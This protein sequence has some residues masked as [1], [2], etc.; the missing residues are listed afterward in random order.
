MQYKNLKK[1][2]L[3]LLLLLIFIVPFVGLFHFYYIQKFRIRN[4]IKHSILNGIDRNKLVYFCFSK[5]YA[6]NQLEWEFGN[7]FEFENEMYDVVESKI[8]GDSVEYWCWW[9]KEETELNKLLHQLVAEN[10]GNSPVNNHRIKHLKYLLKSLYS[11]DISKKPYFPHC[12]KHWQETYL[13][14]YIPFDMDTPYP[15]P[16][17]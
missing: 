11:K 6:Q 5:N 4:E 10:I 12:E 14:N 16:E 3:T 8:K 15:P 1:K 7:E 2:L 9:D 17:V 13:I